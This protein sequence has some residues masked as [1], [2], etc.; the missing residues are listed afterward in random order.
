MTVQAIRP[1]G[2]VVAGL[3]AAARA[4]ASAAGV[5]P[6]SL[7]DDELTRAVEGSSVLVNQVAAF[8]LALLAEADRRRLAKRLGATGTDAW[9]ATLTG[10]TRGVMAGGIWLA[11]LLEERYPTTRDAFAAGGINQAQAR[12]IVR[13][14][15]RLPSWVSG[16][17]RTAAEAGLV[18]K[19]VH[20]MDA[21]GL[22]RAARRM[23]DQVASVSKEEVDAHE[24]DQLEKDEQRAERET[25]L[26][27][28]DNGDGTWSGKFT[29]PDLHASLLRAFLQRLCSPTRLTRNTA[30]QTVHDETVATGVNSYER[31]GRALT[32]L[33]EHLP[34]DGFGRGG[35]GVMVHLDHQHLLDGL[36]S[37]RLDTGLDISA[38]QARRLAC[39]AG[40]IPT[41]LNGD[42]V[43]LDLG[44]T[45]RLH[46][47]AQARAL[48]VTYETCAAEGC[49][50]PFAWC[51][52]HHPHPW[53]HGGPTN[54]DNALPLCGWHH[55]RAHDPTF[56]TKKM[57]SGEVRFTR[58]R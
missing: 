16:E 19:A 45:R 50:R 42:S 4:V 5:P 14:A 20:G 13:A 8:N 35:I 56:D 21:K 22:R 1:E 11:R 23:L 41:V 9:A 2:Q 43:V 44:R 49:S 47:P 39:T 32:E 12:V 55:Q 51:D 34:Q 25:N 54:L 52:I 3:S 29:I 27:L 10:T 38:G 33:I 58:R 15:E 18:V 26:A 7:S 36:A 57:P 17:H 48:S 30:G 53:S 28:W 37:A 24:A 6:V 31:Q 46:T 40:I